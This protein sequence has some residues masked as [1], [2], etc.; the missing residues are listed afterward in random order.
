MET[1][2]GTGDGVV[3]GLGVGDGVDAGFGEPFGAGVGVGNPTAFM[4]ELA[5]VLSIMAREINDAERAAE[6]I[7]LLR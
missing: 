2:V 1:G 4:T 3:A 5:E 6:R 7:I